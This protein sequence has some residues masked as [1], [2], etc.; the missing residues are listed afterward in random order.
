MKQAHCVLLE[1]PGSFRVAS[2][3]EILKK[4]QIQKKQRNRKFIYSTRPLL[5]YYHFSTVFLPYNG[6]SGWWMGK[7]QIILHEGDSKKIMLL[8]GSDRKIISP[9]IQVRVSQNILYIHS[10]CIQ[11]SFP[12]GKKDTAE[13]R[14]VFITP[15]SCLLKYINIIKSPDISFFIL[16]IYIKTTPHKKKM[17]SSRIFIWAFI[18]VQTSCTIYSHNLF[19][20]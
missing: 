20:V 2:F 10:G 12:A 6:N 9:K 5:V 13:V 19:F 4:R 8:Q 18:L 3:S 7:W 16:K 15:N 14:Q 17:E 1:W 11:W